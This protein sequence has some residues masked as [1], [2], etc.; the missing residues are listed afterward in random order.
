MHTREGLAA[1]RY[2]YKSCPAISDFLTSKSIVGNN[3]VVKA[4]SVSVFIG[5]SALLGKRLDFAGATEIYEMTVEDDYRK[6]GL[7][8][9]DGRILTKLILENAETLRLSRQRVV[10]GTKH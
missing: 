2:F 1:Y 10:T 9:D 4:I 7:L 6:Y 8:P 5:E 3:E